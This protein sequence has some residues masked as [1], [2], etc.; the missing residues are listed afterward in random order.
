MSRQTCIEQ[1]CTITGPN[2]QPFKSGGAWIG[3]HKNTGQLGGILYAYLKEHKVGDWHGQKK[4]PAVFGREWRSNMGDTRQVVSFRLYG[5]P[6]A[7]IYY[8]SGS[9]IVRFREVQQ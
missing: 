7:G 3:K 2:G 4:V 8:K 9:D 6:C 1:N 5:R